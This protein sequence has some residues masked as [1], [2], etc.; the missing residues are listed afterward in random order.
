MLKEIEI[1]NQKTENSFKELHQK[2]NIERE[3]MTQEQERAFVTEC[4]RIYEEGGF[5][6]TFHSNSDDFKKHNGKSFKVIRRVTDQECDLISQPMWQIELE[7][8]NKFAAFS[9]EITLA[10]QIQLF[11]ADLIN[12]SVL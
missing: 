4:Y 6:K 3:A 2:Y 10:D 8:G 12:K 7:D 5:A 11:A 9:E 1:K